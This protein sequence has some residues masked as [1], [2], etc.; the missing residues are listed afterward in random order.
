MTSLAARNEA[1][2]FTELD[3]TVV[4]MDAD[5]G[6]YYELDPVGARIWALLETARPVAEVCDALVAEYEVAPDTCRADVLAFLEEAAGRGIIR[7]RAA[8][9]PEAGN[10]VTPTR[11]DR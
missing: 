8:K 5:E 11:R 7:L 6:R 3:D 9:P 1:L 10:D 4:M 2:I